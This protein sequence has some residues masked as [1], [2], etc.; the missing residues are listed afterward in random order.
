MQLLESLAENI[1][2]ETYTNLVFS[3]GKERISAYN[4]AFQK[5]IEIPGEIVHYRNL[6]FDSPKKWIIMV[7]GSL[8]GMTTIDFVDTS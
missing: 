1:I 8:D 7:I 2:A 6:S 5:S 3:R 4:K